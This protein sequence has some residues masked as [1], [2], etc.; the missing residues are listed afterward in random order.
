MSF[1]SHSSLHAEVIAGQDEGISYTAPDIDG[2]DRDEVEQFRKRYLKKHEQKWLYE[3]L[4]SGET[5]RH[6]IRKRLK[7][8]KM[9]R[10]IEYLPIIES[11]YK[12][13]AIPASG[14]SVG[15]WQ[16][17]E[18]SVHPYLKLDEWI[19]E[20]RDP[21]KSTD[22]AIKKLKDN[23]MMFGD[24][25]IAIAAYNC[26]AGAMK[27]ALRNSEKKDFWSLS[28]QKLIPEHTIR[29]IPNFLAVSDVI[30]NAAYYGMELPEIKIEDETYSPFY[31]FDYVT[32]K[33]QVSLERI[34]AEL[35][36]DTQILERLNLALI[37]GCT[38]PD[39]EYTIRIPSGM[40]VSAEE[41]LSAI[42]NAK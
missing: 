1:F 35:R 6:Y 18:N 25:Q 38:P 39:T 9:P 22:A 41:A 3:I 30:Q 14:K 34:A 29:Y 42:Y 5:Y 33:G 19:D 31:D 11:S 28:A 37:R 23:Y 15:M 40:K 20:R 32:V 10:C 17:M 12:P 2:A 26:G 24:W 8:E 13:T 7:E 16:F 27:K 36:L 4:D 21:W